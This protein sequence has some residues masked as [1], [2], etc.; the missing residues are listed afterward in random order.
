MPL[1]FRHHANVSDALKEYETHVTEG[2]SRA[3][4][5]RHE[6]KGRGIVGGTS[7]R[8]VSWDGLVY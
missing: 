3:A 1:W 6:S 2:V 8:H 4:L 7:L 5:V